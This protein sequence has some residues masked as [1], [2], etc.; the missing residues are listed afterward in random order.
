MRPADYRAWPAVTARRRNNITFS[1]DNRGFF[2]LLHYY[3]YSINFFTPIRGQT[4][5]TI[6]NPECHKTTRSLSLTPSLCRSL[7]ISLFPRVA[8]SFGPRVAPLTDPLRPRV[9]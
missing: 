7:T 4:A 3:Y 6:V 9:L 5:I 8:R 2:F 1:T